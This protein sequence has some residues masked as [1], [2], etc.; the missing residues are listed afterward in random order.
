MTIWFTE[1]KMAVHT[2]PPDGYDGPVLTDEEWM[3]YVSAPGENYDI[4]DNEFVPLRTPEQVQARERAKMELSENRSYLTRTDYVITKISEAR[5]LGEDVE[6]LLEQYAD[7]I[8]AR[9]QARATVSRLREEHDLQD[10]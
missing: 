6:S 5:A 9:K 8:E 7:I 3:K 2:E 1:E 4:I 10:W